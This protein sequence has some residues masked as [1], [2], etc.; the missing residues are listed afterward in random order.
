MFTLLIS[1]YLVNSHKGCVHSDWKLI[2]ESERY[3]HDTSSQHRH[4]IQF[5][6]TQTIIVAALSIKMLSK[7]VYC[8]ISV[9]VGLI[10][11]DVAH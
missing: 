2:D 9:K 10:S 11:A 1:C 8:D 7:H 5:N 3:Q 6:A 4:F